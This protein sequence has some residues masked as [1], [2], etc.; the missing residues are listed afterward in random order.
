MTIGISEEKTIRSFKAEYEKG[1]V[2]YTRIIS[3]KPDEFKSDH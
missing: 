1:E 2:V 3:Q